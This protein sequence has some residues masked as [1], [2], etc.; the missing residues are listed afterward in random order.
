MRICL[1]TETEEAGGE[2]RAGAGGGGPATAAI[3]I[4][5]KKTVLKIERTG[6]TRAIK[7]LSCQLYLSAC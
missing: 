4:K 3:V 2:W 5:R 7:Q 1:E 6:I